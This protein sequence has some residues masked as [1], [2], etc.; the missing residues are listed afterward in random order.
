MDIP[1]LKYL[2]YTEIY[3]NAPMTKYIVLINSRK[4]IMKHRVAAVKKFLGCCLGSFYWMRHL[5][6]PEIKWWL[7]SKLKK[8]AEKGCSKYILKISMFK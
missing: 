4:N 3:F 6:V 5:N 2:R 7:H 1:L 8:T